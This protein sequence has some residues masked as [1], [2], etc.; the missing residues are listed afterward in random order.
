[1]IWRHDSRDPTPYPPSE[2]QHPKRSPFQKSPCVRKHL[3]L[4]VTHFV[5]LKNGSGIVASG[6][7]PVRE[8]EDCGNLLV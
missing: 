1:M 6:H 8:T 3:G 4:S 2:A 5:N 7:I